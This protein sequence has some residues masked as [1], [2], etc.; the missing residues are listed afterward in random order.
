MDTE[1]KS[2]ESRLKKQESGY[3]VDVMI[4][5]ECMD[6]AGECEHTKRPVKQQQNPV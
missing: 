4:P 5:P 1:S 3:I 2:N 6:D